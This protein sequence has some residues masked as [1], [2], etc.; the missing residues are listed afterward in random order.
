MTT[1]LADFVRPRSRF[2]RSAN[3]ERDHGPKAID[4]YVPTGRAV[5]VIARISRGLSEPAAGR[6]F[7]ITG[8]HGGG[9]SSLA[10]FLDSLVAGSSTSEFKTAHSIL[11]SVDPDIDASLKAG[12]RAVGGSR[13]G[14][15]RAFATARSE[16]VAATIAHALHSAAVREH[17]ADQKIVPDSFRSGTRTPSNAE[18]GECVRGICSTRPMLLVID[19]FGKN[20]EYFAASGNGGD[21]FLLQELAEATQ[22]ETAIPLVIITLQHSAFDEYVQQASTARRRE[23]AKVQGR[24]QDV[25]Y[26]ETSSQ[27]RKLIA[28]ALE[29]LSARFTESA[30]KWVEKHRKQL[31]SLGYRDLVDDVVSALPLHPLVLAVLPDLCSRYG[32]NERTL[33]SFLTGSEPSAVPAVLA[34]TPWSP[35]KP[36]PVVGLDLLYD[37]FL[38]SSASMIGVADSA[39]RWVEIE[40][41]IRD[42]AGLSPVQLRAVKAIGVLNLISS[43]GRIRA[44]RSMVEFALLGR[45]RGAL[46]SASVSVDKTLSELVD[47]GLVTY[48]AFSD[49]YRIWQGSDY[50]L[51]RVIDN[52][53][54]D[55]E[56]ADLATL[57]NDSA[58]LEP[59]VAG[60]H[61]QRT[62]VLRVF[63]QKFSSLHDLAAERIDSTWDGIVYYATDPEARLDAMP[64]SASGRPI[65]VVVPSDVSSVRDAAVEAAA[66][67]SALKTAEDEGVDWVARRELVERTAAAQ[68][69]VQV[70][71]GTTWNSEADWRLISSGDHLDAHRGVSAVLSD[72]C[73]LVYTA[74]PRVANEM[75][76]RRE[77]TSRARRL[78][79][80]WSMRCSTKRR[81]RLSASKDAGR[82]GRSTRRLSA[83][84]EFIGLM[85]RVNGR[86][87]HQQTDRGKPYGRP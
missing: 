28:W 2:S 66:L 35:N 41:R 68:Q 84:R 49:E 14:F 56:D 16:P 83:R 69:M 76:A 32:Q 45:E 86:S 52:A 17:G 71:I 22:G 30:T 57:L 12:I 42:S 78:V 37:Y 59:A 50:D 29:P 10:I 72:V 60:R 11:E 73:D 79:D 26:V 58:V 54:H 61:S 51:R 39:S 15:L 36:M 25:P 70:L 33:F 64:A 81:L 44:S 19:E 4:G 43:G 38:E 47:A 67:T 34:A 53:R 48:R 27:S 74:T 75:I 18:I 85:S 40:T 65:V 9:K 6:A 13:T 80:F 55:C 62:G 23:W 24:F 7:S 3:I 82:T 5:D 21:P 77:L 87:V 31:E 46:Q 63:T 20:L 8:P 1:T